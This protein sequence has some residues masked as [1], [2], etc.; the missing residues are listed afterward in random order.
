MGFEDFFNVILFGFLGLVMIYAFLSP[1]NT[2]VGQNTDF[3]IN[4]ATNLSNTNIMV[5]LLPLTGLFIIIIFFAM[6]VK[7][8]FPGQGQ[9]GAGF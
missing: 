3:L 7:Q 6:L 2:I 9:P 4:N 8:A 5:F 1:I